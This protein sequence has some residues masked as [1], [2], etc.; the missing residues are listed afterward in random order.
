LV[1][2][3]GYD[4][5][6]FENEEELAILQEYILQQV[7]KGEERQTRKETRQIKKA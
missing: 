7:V 3:L 4:I 2:F 5:K 1:N 6:E